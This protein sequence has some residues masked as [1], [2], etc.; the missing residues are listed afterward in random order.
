MT[1]VPDFRS[2]FPDE[3]F[4]SFKTEFRILG[5][6]FNLTK[7]PYT[8]CFNKKR[9]PQLLNINESNKKT[10]LFLYYTVNIKFFSIKISRIFKL[11]RYLQQVG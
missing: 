8:N 11:T 2:I 1:S 9:Y 7:S 4:R 6:T 5:I 10:N 3:N